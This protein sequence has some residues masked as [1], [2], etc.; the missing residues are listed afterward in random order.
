LLDKEKNRRREGRVERVGRERDEL[1]ILE[2][3]A[4]GQS[5]KD[6]AFDTTCLTGNF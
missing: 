3:L 1:R 4:V 2:Q 5:L 6:V